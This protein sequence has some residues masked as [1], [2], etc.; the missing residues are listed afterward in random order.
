MVKSPVSAR[1]GNLQARREESTRRCLAPPAGHAARATQ[2]R[3]FAC[4]ITHQ[5]FRDGGSASDRGRIVLVC[6]TR[7]RIEPS[8][9]AV[10]F[11]RIAITVEEVSPPV[12][13]G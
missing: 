7:P 5:L 9:T 8:S 11:M 1:C 3:R 13:D 2:A 12:E 4:A 10:A 6:E